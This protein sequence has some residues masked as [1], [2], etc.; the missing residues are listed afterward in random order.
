MSLI[1]FFFLMKNIIVEK[2][3]FIKN[4]NP[5]KINM[6]IRKNF[7]TVYTVNNYNNLKLFPYEDNQE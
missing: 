1:Y 7:N 4:V 3:G 6:E 2:R 5:E